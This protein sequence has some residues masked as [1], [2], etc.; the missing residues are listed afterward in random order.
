MIVYQKKYITTYVIIFIIVA[1]TVILFFRP[2]LFKSIKHFILNLN[3]EENLENRNLQV[4]RDPHISMQSVGP[5]N[6]STTIKK[7]N[8]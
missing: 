6:I 5:W 7:E 8:I 4:R 1:I 3:I 2:Y